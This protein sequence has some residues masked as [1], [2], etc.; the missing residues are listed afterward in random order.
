MD[1]FFARKLK[2]MLQLLNFVK[3][4]HSVLKCYVVM[5][6]FF[7]FV[8]ELLVLFFNYIEMYLFR[9]LNK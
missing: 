2:N 3:Q 8:G 9:K 5:L 6:V 4:T 7:F 1:G